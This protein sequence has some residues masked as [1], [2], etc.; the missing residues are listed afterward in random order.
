M[1]CRKHILCLRISKGAGVWNVGRFLFS[2]DN[3]GPGYGWNASVRIVDA[4]FFEDPT[5]AL[6]AARDFSNKYSNDW[7]T[8][9]A[10]AI[11]LEILG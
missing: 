2:T 8:V 9:N 4:D 11:T 5:S 10:E 7:Q 1:V 3:N 6:V